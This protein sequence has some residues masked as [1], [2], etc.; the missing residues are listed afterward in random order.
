[1][2]CYSGVLA[3]NSKHPYQ[4]AER[5]EAKRHQ[6]EDAIYY[7]HPIFLIDDFEQVVAVP[8]K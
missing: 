3:H 4:Q 2:I 1:M 8:K 5:K 7:C 6:Q